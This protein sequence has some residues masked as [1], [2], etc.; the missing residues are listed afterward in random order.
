MH[1]MYDDDSTW[2]YSIIWEDVPN[3]DAFSTDQ[4]AGHDYNGPD[5]A[6]QTIEDLTQLMQ[7]HVHATSTREK[8][9]YGEFCTHKLPS[10]DGSTNPW[11]AKSLI[12]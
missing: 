11:A 2:C 9:L 6:F 5:G 7:G 1:Q 12:N 3:D 8:S 10:F 4:K